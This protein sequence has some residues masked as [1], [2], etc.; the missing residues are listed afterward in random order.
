MAILQKPHQNVGN[1]EQISGIHE[2]ITTSAFSK[3]KLSRNPQHQRNPQ[4]VSGLRKL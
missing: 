4:I 2:Q 3:N 1:S